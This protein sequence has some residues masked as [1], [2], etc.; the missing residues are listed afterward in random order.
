MSKSE[1]RLFSVLI[2]FVRII[3]WIYYLFVGYYVLMF[4]VIFSGGKTIDIGISD[5]TILYIGWEL[6]YYIQLF[7]V[8]VFSII[9]RFRYREINIYLLCNILFAIPEFIY[10]GFKYC[11]NVHEPGGLFG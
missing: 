8:L 4:I 5:R 6:V 11:S 7:V 9:S 3:V 1:N 2:W 10:L